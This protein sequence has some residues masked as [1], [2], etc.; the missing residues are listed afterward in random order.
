MIY[1]VLAVVLSVAVFFKFENHKYRAMYAAAT[2]AVALPVFSI[3]A[4]AVEIILRDVGLSGVA[5]EFT[6]QLSSAFTSPF[7]QILGGEVNMASVFPG[8]LMIAGI[9][10]TGWRVFRS[11]QQNRPQQAR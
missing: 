7:N 5:T 6:Y 11:S 1:S 4:Y 3:I 9:I 8:Y 2:C 10:A